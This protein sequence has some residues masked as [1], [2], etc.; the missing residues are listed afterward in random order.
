MERHITCPYD[1]THSILPDRMGK[2]LRK[3]SV[4]NADIASKMKTCPFS[5]THVLKP[6]DYD[7]HVEECPCR[8]VICTWIPQSKV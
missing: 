3:C 1:P 2:H 5:L 4:N 7:Q 6:E 8:N